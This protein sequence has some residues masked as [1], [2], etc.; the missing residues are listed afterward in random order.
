M[1]T[2]T[3]AILYLITAT[4]VGGGER[5]VV[6]LA[7]ELVR[8][9]GRVLLISMTPIG[10]LGRDAI[11][12]GVAVKSLNMTPGW[13]NAVALW[14]FRRIVQSFRPDVV[15]AHMFHASIFARVSRLLFRMPALVCSA[16]TTY[17]GGAWRIFL[18]R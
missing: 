17:E 18:Y 16:H 10:S 6:D 11:R 5:Q 4:G 14:R 2:T 12:N 15:H 7:T 8:R 3:K 13:P 9:G 1:K